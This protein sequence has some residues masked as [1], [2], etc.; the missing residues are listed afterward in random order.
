MTATLDEEDNQ[1]VS[2]NNPQPSEFPETRQTDNWNKEVNETGRWGTRSQREVIVVAGTILLV[3]ITV[4]VGVSVGVVMKKE[5]T[6]SQG[7]GVTTG[8][9]IV[10]NGER[11][12]AY[13]LPTPTTPTKLDNPDEELTFLREELLQEVALKDYMKY[14]PTSVDEL[15]G[16]MNNPLASPYARAASWLVTE[17][18]DNVKE[19]ALNRFALATI[20]YQNGGGNWTDAGGWLARDKNHCDWEGV[21]CC[22]GAMQSS[23]ICTNTHFFDVVE[24]DLSKKNLKGYIPDALVLLKSLVSIIM[25]ENKLIGPIPEHV[26]TALPS[27]TKLYLQHNGLTGT[28]PSG[29]NIGNRLGECVC[30]CIEC[31]HC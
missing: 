24:L 16:V 9:T 6:G 4:V 15:R 26:F 14:I 1:G 29:L 19:E 12:S 5:D 31:A 7:D 18:T 20:Y 2:E 30:L 27:F 13:K 8:A 28:I 21:I 25:S 3:I 23:L 17:D 11:L 10:V 22:A